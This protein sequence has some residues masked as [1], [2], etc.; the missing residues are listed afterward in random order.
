MVRSGT[1]IVINTESAR[2]MALDVLSKI[3][4]EKPMELIISRYSPTRTHGQNA[5]LWKW[6][7]EVASELAFSTG[8]P[9]TAEQVHYR[10][11]CPKFLNGVVCQLPDGSKAWVSET[12]STQSTADLSAA[13]ESYLAWCVQ[14]GIDLTV[15]EDLDE[16][17]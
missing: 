1:R 8:Q 11:F 6:H 15:P 7:N 14:W 4:I 10:V 12:S 3:D 16:H 13:M 5:L 9:W 17:H 2:R